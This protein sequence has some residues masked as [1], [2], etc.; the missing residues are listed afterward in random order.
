MSTIGSLVVIGA[1]ALSLNIGAEFFPSVDAGLIQLHVRAPARTRIERTEQIFQAIEDNIRAH[2]SAKDLKLMIDNI[3]LPARVFNLAFT[4]GS[5]IGV[6]DG[7][8]QIEL[9]EDHQ[10][11][12]EI[13][14]KLRAELPIA[15]PDV[16]FYFQPA[17]LITQV[18]NFGV[19]TQI[20]VQIQ[21]RDRENNTKAA[22]LLQ[23][24]M[25][26]VGHANADN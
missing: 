11:T 20:D 5:A 18:L 1:V 24:K 25:A 7:V 21:G 2:V 19:P 9:G 12:A 10:P 6:N 15:F 16:L 17:D 26:A 3:G 22:A 4:D 8:I 23:K 13:I 14:E